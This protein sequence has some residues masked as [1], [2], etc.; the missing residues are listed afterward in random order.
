M[1]A[2]NLSV[3]PQ[4]IDQ[5]LTPQDLADLLALLRSAQ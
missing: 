2:S 4:G 1:Q 3:M 5:L